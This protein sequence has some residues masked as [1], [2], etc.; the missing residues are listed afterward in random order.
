MNE[1]ISFPNPRLGDPDGLLAIN[2]DLST[3]RLLLAYS[4]GTYFGLGKKLGTFGYSVRK[5][6]GGRPK[7]KK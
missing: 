1:E 7:R 4:H 5:T 3:E 6:K 2:G